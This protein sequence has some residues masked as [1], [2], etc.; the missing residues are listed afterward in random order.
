M[1]LADLSNHLQRTLAPNTV[2]AS[3]SERLSYECDA[4]VLYKAVPGL[5][6]VPKTPEDVVTTVEAC[7]EQGVPFVARGAGTG[8]SGGAL[9]PDN[10][11]LICLNQLTKVIE[12]NVEQRYAWVE[13]GVVNAEFNRQLAQYNLH[14]SPDPSSQIACTL[15]GN[16]AENAGGIHCFKQGVTTDHV[17]AVEGV[18]AEGNPFRYGHPSFSDSPFAAQKLW[19]GSEGTLGVVT[20][21]CV[22]LS[23]RPQTVQVVLAAFGK[24]EEAADCVSTI[25]R[26]GIQPSAMEYLDQPTVWAV[27]KTF[28][29][30]FPSDCQ[31]VL[32][33]EVAGQSHQVEFEL[34]E[35]SKI[36]KRF[37]P[38]Q[39]E[40]A[41]TPERC[42]KLWKV[43]KMSVGA[44]GQLMPA[45]YVHDCVIP[46]SRLKEVLAGIAAIGQQYGVPVANVFHAADGN[47]HPNL[48]FD[49][50]IEG[51]RE[52]V[53]EAGDAILA[54]CLEMG[55]TL[56]G[57]HGI[58]IEKRGYMDKQFSETDLNVMLR[59]KALYD[60]KQ[61][62]NP[63]K[64][65]PLKHH[66]GEGG[67]YETTA[68]GAVRKWRQ[69]DIELDTGDDPKLWI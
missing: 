63:D 37:N 59:A 68:E 25:I 44:Y 15:G 38:Q 31:A 14:Y 5:V 53:I 23:P 55:G 40:I 8:L 61:L 65:F 49:P 35:L 3:D 33:A 26:Q 56:S 12:L 30:G 17:L 48:L 39:L 28:H 42:Q 60:P 66:C 62:A 1:P 11:V 64:L 47:L 7:Y 34:D 16:I 27:N 29:M 52:I 2:L 18:T 9:C 43:R 57:E 69:P 67:L 10:A 21:A 45:F 32:I 22:K 46:R 4:C 6:V 36:V 54:L 58:G 41:T 19:I 24:M 20:K 51:R 50:H 13:V